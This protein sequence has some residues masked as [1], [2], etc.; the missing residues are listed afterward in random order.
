MLYPDFTANL[1][2][3]NP[4]PGQAHQINVVEQDPTFSYINRLGAKKRS[5]KPGQ[6]A[7]SNTRVFGAAEV[8]DPANVRAFPLNQTQ[9]FSTKQQ[10]SNQ[11]MRLGNKL[12]GS[13]VGSKQD[14]AGEFII[15]D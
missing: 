6:A 8:N 15:F 12:G 9:N 1:G 5:R 3:A 11:E 13:Q 4:Q 10:D 14:D 2:G 7:V